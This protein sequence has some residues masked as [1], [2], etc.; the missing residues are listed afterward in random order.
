MSFWRSEEKRLVEL[1]EPSYPDG[2]TD[3]SIAPCGSRIVAWRS[4]EV[5]VWDAVTGALVSEV[6][7]QTPV[8][9]VSNDGKMVATGVGSVT[10]WTQRDL[11]SEVGFLWLAICIGAVG[12]IGVRA[13]AARVA[14]PRPPTN[15]NVH[16]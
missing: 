12:A 8:L 4:N 9:G 6:E 10:I 3:A 5:I 15:R 7:F 16:C 11:T 1:E 13:A 14:T 2:Y